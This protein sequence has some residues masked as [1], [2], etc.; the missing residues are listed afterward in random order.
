[1][2]VENWEAIEVYCRYD[3]CAEQIQGFDNK[4]RLSKRKMK[5]TGQEFWG[6]AV[7]TC[8]VC[9]RERKYRER[10]LGTGYKEI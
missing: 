9:G 3:E 2:T 6:T 4:P 5:F 10:T 1:M 8:P 7:F